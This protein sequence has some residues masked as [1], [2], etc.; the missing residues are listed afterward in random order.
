MT[1][2]RQRHLAGMVATVLAGLV[3]LTSGGR[4]DPSSAFSVVDST[5]SP[6]VLPAAPMRIVSL[7]PSATEIIW[8]V[9]GQDRLAGVTDFCDFPAAARA[10][11]RVGGMIAPSL[12][13][14][15]ALRP[16]V[17][18]VT[19]EGNRRETFDQ[20]RRLGIPTY[21]VAPQSVEGVLATVVRLGELTGRASAG[22]AL[23]RNL[24]QRIDAVAAR[25]APL[26]RPRVLYVVWPDPLIVPGR[27][28][29][30]S[31]LI[32]LAGGDSVTAD[33]PGTYPRYSPEAAIARSPQ[34]IFLARHAAGAAGPGSARDPLTR[35]KW[36]RFGGLPAIRSGRRHAVDGGLLHRYGPRMVDGLEA[37]AR[38]TH[39]EAFG[40]TGGGPGS[41]SRP[42]SSTMRTGRARRT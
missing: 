4:P 3:A 23:A 28:A 31:E 36:E 38:L 21:Q 20:L 35:E 9:G 12:E 16:D 32:R 18:I 34:V 5:G 40:P 8:A 14:I 27:A 26:P 22:Q 11:P 29:L 42:G 33:V 7:V 17:V 39:P 24:R 6:V 25:V 2:R 30:V 41:E 15:V 10:K 19:S 13:A 1:T 37:L